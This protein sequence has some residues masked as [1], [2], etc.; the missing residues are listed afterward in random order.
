LPSRLC[1]TAIV[2]CSCGESP[3]TRCAYCN[4][5]IASRLR[6]TDSSEAIRPAVGIDG[7]GSGWRCS[8]GAPRRPLAFETLHGQPAVIRVVIIGRGQAQARDAGF[9]VAG[10]LRGAADQYSHD[11]R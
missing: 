5:F 10:L 8:V 1:V 2:A 9:D 7:D 4:S 3:H 11:G 6:P